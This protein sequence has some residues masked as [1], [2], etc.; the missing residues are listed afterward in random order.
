MAKK[1]ARSHA[2]LNSFSPVPGLATRAGHGES[3]IG[4][5]P[6]DMLKLSEKFPEKDVCTSILDA[7]IVYFVKPRPLPGVFFPINF[8]K[9][10]ASATF[11]GADAEAFTP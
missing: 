7:D 4:P 9:N 10:G 6:F 2:N 11:A 1:V 8:A 3:G 5:E